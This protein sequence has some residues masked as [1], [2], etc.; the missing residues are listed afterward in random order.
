MAR[1]S[2]FSRRRCS[3]SFKADFDRDERRLFLSAPLTAGS[4]DRL[5]SRVDAL[6]SE[7]QGLQKADAALPRTQLKNTGLAIAM[8]AWELSSFTVLRREA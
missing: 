1:W 4:L 5:V 6:A 7:F 3:R 2:A 8:R